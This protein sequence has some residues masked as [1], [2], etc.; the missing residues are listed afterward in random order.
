MGMLAM[1]QISFLHVCRYP[2][3]MRTIPT[4]EAPAKALC[5][6][7]SED[8]GMGFG[9]EWRRSGSPAD[10]SADMGHA[11]VVFME[12]AY[13]TA[14]ANGLISSCKAVGIDVQAFGFE[15][16]N[17]PTIEAAIESLK[18]SGITIVMVVAIG[19]FDLTS[20]VEAA[21]DEG[22]FDQ[23]SWWGFSDGITLGDFASLPKAAGEALH[24]SFRI[25]AVGGTDDNPRWTQFA[26]DWPSRE[27][28]SYN[29][30]PQWPQEWPLAP[31]FFTTY[32]NPSGGGNLRDIGAYEY[33]AIMYVGLM[34]CKLVP[35]GALPEDFGKRFLEAK[36]ELEFDGLSGRVRFNDKGNR[37]EDSANVW[38][39]NVLADAGG[40]MWN[41]VLLAKYGG[42]A[43]QPTGA[44][45]LYNGGSSTMPPDCVPGKCTSPPWFFN[46]PLGHMSIALVLVLGIGWLVGLVLGVRRCRKAVRRTREMLCEVEEARTMRIMGAAGKLSTLSYS[47]CFVHFP[48]LRE[49]GKLVAHEQ[50]RKSGDLVAI[51]DFVELKSFLGRYP[52]VFISHQWLGGS[53]PDPQ[54]VHF[55]AIQWAVASLCDEFELHSDDLYVWLDYSSMPQKNPVLQ[56]LAIDTLSVYASVCKFFVVIAPETVHESG[57]VCDAHSYSR[58][59]WCRLEQWARIAVGGL[60]HIYLHSAEGKPLK[61]IKDDAAWLQDSIFVIG[62]DFTMPDDKLKLV[63]IILALWG[64][65]L[66]TKD[67]S[68]EK[69]ELYDQVTKSLSIVFPE[70]YFGDLIARME[71]M[72]HAGEDDTD[73]EL[74]QESAIGSIQQVGNIMN[75]ALQRRESVSEEAHRAGAPAMSAA[76]STELAI[77]HAEHAI[78]HATHSAEHAIEHAAHSAEHA[79][80]HAAQEVEH[81][82]HL[83]KLLHHHHHSTDAMLAAAP[84]MPGMLSTAESTKILKRTLGRAATRNDELVQCAKADQTATAKRKH[85]ARQHKAAKTIQARVRLSFSAATGSP[86]QGPPKQGAAASSPRGSVAQRMREHQAA[87]AI[88]LRARVKWFGKARPPSF[89]SPRKEPLKSIV[90]TVGKQVSGFFSPIVSPIAGVLSPQSKKSTGV[91]L[92]GSAPNP[93][94]SERASINERLAPLLAFHGHSRS[95]GKLSAS[96]I[97]PQRG[98]SAV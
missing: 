10:S 27:V 39:T 7:W 41:E 52:T 73:G 58:R 94:M 36:E 16:V 74:V 65:M 85:V 30:D 78:Q 48:K 96:A 44:E 6:Y 72:Y 60:H 93:S 56:K 34:A 66:R 79:I 37:H 63:D 13:G 23:P 5:K 61:L 76:L 3:F 43:W 14:Y 95:T 20:I 77:R 25:A 26:D 90:E 97:A 42:G 19:L 62:G 69:K 64:C 28:E 54:N 80:E 29:G 47:M 88:Q 18:E 40:G 84:T 67:Q 9:A 24:G 22:I 38:L 57:K 46:T 83:D 86:K 1:A 59:G 55:D 87:T 33:D 92:T 50:L 81:A 75:R 98:S 21:L 68:P 53:F 32:E 51:D 31:D 45:M 8:T 89:E 49:F 70:Q 4:D 71:S 15:T 12:D 11:A 2:S 35:I 91:T 82:L 17:K